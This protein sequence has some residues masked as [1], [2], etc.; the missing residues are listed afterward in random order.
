MAKY[1]PLPPLEEL[2][3]RFEYDPDSG[4]FYKKGKPVGCCRNGG[5]ILL[6]WGRKRSLYA[7]RVAWFLMTGVDPMDL[8]I[9]HKNGDKKDNK[10]TNLRACTHQQNSWNARGE[11]RG[12]QK[13]GDRY[14]VR[15]RHGYKV[16]RGGVFDSAEEAQAAYRAK[17]VELRGEFAP[18]YDR[19]VRGV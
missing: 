12:Y 9:D 4:L 17:A 13:T 14:Y 5:Y 8:F 11:S 19:G 18:S 16:L 1:K 10:F 2:K 3:D 6:S 7:H 15:L